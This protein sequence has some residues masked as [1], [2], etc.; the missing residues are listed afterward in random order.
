MIF[1]LVSPVKRSGSSNSYFAQRI[2]ADVRARATGVSLAIPLGELTLSLTIGPNAASVRFS[3]RTRDP[4]EVKIRQ[5]IAAAYLETVWQALRNNQPVT[6]THKD[7]TA[8]AGELY[9]AWANGEGRE[10]TYAVEWD[11]QQRK[12][13]PAEV[14][15]AEEQLFFGAG[16]SHLD[17][18]A[19]NENPA[20]LELGF[21]KLI[22][23]LL[24]VK[25]ISSLDP[26][27]RPLL[28]EAFR[29]ALR[30]AFEARERNAS[31][32]YKKDPQAE[33]FPEWTGPDA[34]K[35]KTTAP[36]PAAKVSLTALVEEW[37]REALA[38]G[39]K[40]STHESYRNSM[41]HFVAFLK[42]DDASR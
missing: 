11:A 24:L 25:S 37:W 33:R 30:D 22:D 6:L 36:P 14:T 19:E 26:K 5:G 7:P 28:L 40:P 31:G 8:L 34:A 27:S 2:P 42:H 17:K 32:D 38:A 18:I 16:V 3:L 13:V 39:R 12:M 10:K 35:P 29:L 20:D 4:A 21:G 15:P 23:R 41:A 1:R 9:R